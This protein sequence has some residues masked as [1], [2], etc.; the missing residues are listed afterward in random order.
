MPKKR[1]SVSI[2]AAIKRN[3]AVSAGAELAASMGTGH[4]IIGRA[5]EGAASI[6]GFKSHARSMRAGRVAA[7]IKASR[8][9]K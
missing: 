5:V 1:K 6:F 4:A 8:R 2:S 3:N 7:R 9:K